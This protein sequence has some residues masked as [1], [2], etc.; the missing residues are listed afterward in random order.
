MNRDLLVNAIRIIVL[1]FFQVLILKEINLENSS[2]RYL[3]IIIY[4]LGI[5]LL[6]VSLP[7]FFVILIAFFSG[8][9]VDSFYGSPGVHASACLWM[10]ASRPFV[11]KML[12]P[13][14]GYTIQQ[15]PSS[16]SL[17]IFWFLRFSGILCFVYLFAYFSME[18][19]TFFYIGKILLKTLVSFL[20]SM[21]IIILIKILVN[22]K[23]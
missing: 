16:A 4:Q 18:E 3:N 20:V 8:M 23:E 9:A 1:V 21:F 19:F 17:G 6:P 14:S 7:S 2:S 22:P 11:L 12:E 10:A 5:I 13:K 15:T